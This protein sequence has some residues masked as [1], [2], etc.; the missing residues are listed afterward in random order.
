MPDAGKHRIAIAFDDRQQRFGCGRH[1]R[2]IRHGRRKRL[3]ELAGVA[4]AGQHVAIGQL[5]GI[6]EL[7][8]SSFEPRVPCGPERLLRLTETLDPILDPMLA[9]IFDPHPPKSC[10]SAEIGGF[11]GRFTTQQHRPNGFKRT[12]TLPVP[13][14]GS[15]RPHKPQ[16]LAISFSSR[17]GY[18][19]TSE[20]LTHEPGAPC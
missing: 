6:E 12:T 19:T 7:A 9:P 18:S 17:F 4:K 11:C 8:P 10:I 5:A 20:R 2:P 1:S 16:Y 15:G 13:A 3:D 14:G